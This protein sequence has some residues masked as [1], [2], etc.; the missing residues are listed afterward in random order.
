[1]ADILTLDYTPISSLII[2]YWFPDKKVEFKLL[3]DHL[4]EDLD[5]FATHYKAR[6][7]DSF[8]MCFTNDSAVEALVKNTPVDACFKS[9]FDVDKFRMQLNSLIS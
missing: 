8:I 9:L 3:T 1:M 2:Q 6:F 4:L 5:D 7:P